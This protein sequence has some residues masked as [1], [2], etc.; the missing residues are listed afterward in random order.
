MK[1]NSVCQYS[2]FARGF[3][4]CEARLF[5]GFFVNGIG[6]SGQ[7]NPAGFEISRSAC[8]PVFQKKLQARPKARHAYDIVVH[9]DI[10]GLDAPFPMI[11]HRLSY[12]PSERNPAYHRMDR[13]DTRL[14]G[15]TRVA[16][17]SSEEPA[18]SFAGQMLLGSLVGVFI[19]GLWIWISARVG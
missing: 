14:A 11:D 17:Y 18:C 1:R 3:N 6:V 4:K 8:R 10:H 7:R 15:N 2:G 9:D 13:H 5:I 16:V 19:A 12:P